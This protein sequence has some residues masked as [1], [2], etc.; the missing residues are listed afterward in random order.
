MESYPLPYHGSTIH[1][2][3]FAPIQN[4]AELRK[5][6]VT[7]S[8]LPADE[9]GDSERR[10]VDFAFVDA[11]MITSRLHVL[12][13]VQQ[14]LLARA[15]DSLKTKTLHSEVL[16]MLE[17]GT[18][19]TDS[20][21]HFGLSPSTSSLLLVHIAPTAAT[22]A[23]E[24]AAGEDVLRRMETVVQGPMVALDALGR[25][26]GGGLDEKVVRKVY[27]LNQDAALKG[28]HAG[29]DD[30]LRLLDQLVTSAVALKVAM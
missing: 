5:R 2:A 17:P 7:A 29:S 15:D 27:K 23:D 20:L 8:T 28:L 11:R 1:L 12:T 4:A 24:R 26:E 16:W 18:N 14:A 13:A 21:K 30:A 3:L 9:A 10:A 22:P 6:L 19:I 25:S